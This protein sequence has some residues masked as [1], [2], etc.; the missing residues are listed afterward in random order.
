MHLIHE[1]EEI[2]GLLFDRL[3]QSEAGDPYQGPVRIK[4][5]G[6]NFV[7]EF[8]ENFEHE[9]FEY[10]G[11]LMPPFDTDTEYLGFDDLIKLSKVLD[12]GSRHYR[13][14]L[15]PIVS[16]TIINGYTGCYKL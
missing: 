15:K 1:S 3:V 7:Y 14:T 13:E 8:G 12:E 4:L 10:C 5:V 9:Y 16:Y 11:L 2:L 6:R